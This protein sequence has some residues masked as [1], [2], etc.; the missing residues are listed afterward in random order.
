[1]NAPSLPTIGYHLLRVRHFESIRDNNNITQIKQR[2]IRSRNSNNMFK[3]KHAA[4]KKPHTLLYCDLKMHYA[5]ASVC[6]CRLRGRS[7]DRHIYVYILRLRQYKGMSTQFFLASCDEKRCATPT[8]SSSSQ[9][10]YLLY[11]AW[12]VDTIGE[13]KPQHTNEHLNSKIYIRAYSEKNIYSNIY[14][15]GSI[16]IFFQKQVC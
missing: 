10:P 6:I 14:I 11:E 15:L 9:A 7:T 4:K 2:K 16:Y 5:P 13:A 12:C 8:P 3:Q 1:M